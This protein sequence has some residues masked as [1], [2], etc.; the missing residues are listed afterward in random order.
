MAVDHRRPATGFDKDQPKRALCISASR[1]TL[2]A[3]GLVQ[4][5]GGVLD[6]V[7]SLPEGV[8]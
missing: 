4:S 8:D 1:P 5:A 3:G 2:M 6:K 7:S